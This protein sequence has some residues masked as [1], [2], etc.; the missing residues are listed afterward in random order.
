[1]FKD[2]RTYLSAKVLLSENELE[3]IESYAIRSFPGKRQSL[4]R[5]GEVCQNYTFV[6]KGCVRLFRIMEDGSEH[7]VRFATENWWI[8]D[9]ESLVSG[10]PARSN[11]E[12]LEDCEV[13]QWSKEDFENLQ[14]EIPRF[15]AFFD[16]LLEKFLIANINR[17]YDDIS[18]TAEGKYQHFIKK[19]GDVFN[20]VP[21]HMVASYLG[22]ARETLSR[23][24][25]QSALKNGHN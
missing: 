20:R 25:M 13:L 11:I 24:R 22:L 2:F 9:R 17:I 6:I 8:C 18:L 15:K 21:L 16:Y 12:A 4:L 14:K 19:H 10:E 3:K 1:M 7:I 5:E 23:I